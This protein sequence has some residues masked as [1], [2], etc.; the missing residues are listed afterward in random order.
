MEATWRV[1]F[2][3]E[4][5]RILAPYDV[6]P[7]SPRDTDDFGSGRPRGIGVLVD[8]RGKSLL[9]AGYAR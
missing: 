2:S 6:G 9:D 8:P 4:R 3:D 5:R 7:S 1:E